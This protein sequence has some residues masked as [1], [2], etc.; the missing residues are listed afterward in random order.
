MRTTIFSVLL[1]I[2][3]FAFAECDFE[4]EKKTMNVVVPKKRNKKCT[5]DEF[6]AAFRENLVASIRAMNGQGPLPESTRKPAAG[7]SI[8]QSAQQPIQPHIQHTR[9]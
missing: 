3:A 5:S 6:R 8:G 2:P 4:H 9:R 7:Q 1:L